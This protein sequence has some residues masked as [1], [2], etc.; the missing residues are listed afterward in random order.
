MRLVD[1]EPRWIAGYDASA[2]SMREHT[3]VRQASDTGGRDIT[4]ITIQQAQG[5]MFLCPVCF[6]KNGGPIGTEHVLCWFKDRGIPPDA[7]PGPGRWTATGTSFEDLTL[8]PSVDVDKGHWHGFIQGGEIVGGLPAA[9]QPPLPPPRTV[10]PQPKFNF[11]G[12]R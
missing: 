4:P 10:S 6:L 5:V 3:D 11:Y 2:R 8:S 7:L 9:P 1:L 12:D